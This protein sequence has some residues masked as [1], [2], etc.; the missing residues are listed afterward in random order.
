MENFA[1]RAKHPWPAQVAVY[2]SWRD[3]FAAMAAEMDFYTDDVEVAA[4]ALRLLIA[5]IDTA[6]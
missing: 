5:D 2:P 6:S 1:L 4:D 3:G